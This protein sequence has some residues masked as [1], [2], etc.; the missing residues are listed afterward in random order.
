VRSRTATVIAYEAT[1]QG[2]SDGSPGAARHGFGEHALSVLA[3]DVFGEGQELPATANS[4][5]MRLQEHP[6][7]EANG[8][9]GSRAAVTTT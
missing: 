4:V 6:C 8:S 2:Q 3:G 5:R 7:F 9:F 1:R